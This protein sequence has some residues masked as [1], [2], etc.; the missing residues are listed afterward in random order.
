MKL[1]ILGFL[2]K[3]AASV[4]PFQKLVLISLAAWVTHIILRVL[5]LFRSNPYG[6][7]FVSKPDWFI[8][9]AVCI[10]FLWIVNA[11]VVFLILGGIVYRITAG[12]ATLKAVVVKITTVLY[13]V[14]HTAILLLT[15]LDNETQRF[16]GGHLTFGLVDTYKDTS[17]IIVFYDY[18]ANDL[19]VPYLQ[20][21]VLAL[22]LPLTYGVYRLL[23][24]WYRPSDGFYVKK[25]VIAMLIFYIASYLFVY[26]I[27]T[28][29]ARMTKL[30]PVV[31]LI[32][33]DLF[34]AKKIVGLTDAE[35]GNYRTAYQNLWQKIEGDSDWTFTDS[36][37]GNHLPLY[38]EPMQA[39]LQSEKLKAQREMQPNFILVLMESQRGWNTGYM[40]PQLQP[41]PTPFMDSL[42]AHSHVWM[43]MHTSGVPTTGG[44]LSTHIGI[45]HHSRLAQAT[46]LAHVTIPSFVQVLTTNGYSTHYMSA[47]DP[48]WDNLGV[49]MSKWYTAEHYNRE[50]ED[51]ST[52]ID[53]AIEYVRDTLSKEG[54]PFLATLMT[55][56]NHYPFNFAAGMT[57]EQKN[58]PLQERINVTMNYADRQIARFFHSIENEEWYKNT[59]VIIMADHGFP[60]GENGVSTMN[61]GGF[62]NVSWIPFFIHG[63]GLDAVRDTTPAAQIDVAPT[64]LELA[65]FAVPNIF[66]GHNLLR[67]HMAD[68][69][70]EPLAGLSLGAYSGYAAIG[71]DGYRFIAKYPAQDETHIFADGDLRQ[72]NELTGKLQN[73]EGRA[74]EKFLSATLDTLLKISDYSLERGL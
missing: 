22:M 24:K 5:L 31:S 45:P 36:D 63:K 61:G 74:K 59:Y 38:R 20:F 58:R 47:A 72:E 46:D 49:W 34:V 32:Y 4:A 51:D 71:L 1:T 62:S 33:N 35:L 68:S 69:V 53:H 57:D 29:N 39:L 17:S 64:V 70:P 44:V 40:N 27:W 56:S 26:F 55:R 15:L 23:C 12:K 9:H 14:F 11:L 2:K 18:V 28:G 30:R 50:R 16:L 6:F 10:D 13:A 8:F 19:S 66:M 54:K 73:E 43:R 67:E 3:V 25:S 48:A 37:S 65:G 21:V 52:F 41:S 60:L 42:A 7:P